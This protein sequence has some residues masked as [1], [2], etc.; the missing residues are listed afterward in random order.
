MKTSNYASDTSDNA[1]QICIYEENDCWYADKRSA[2][3]IK[4]AAEKEVV[5]KRTQRFF[6]LLTDR[7]EVDFKA[8]IEKF[9][10]KI[11]SDKKIILTL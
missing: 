10:V 3:I 7:V 2:D 11:C 9:N 6:G 5:K 1:Q 8:M 4:Q